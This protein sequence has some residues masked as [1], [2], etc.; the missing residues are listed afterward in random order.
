MT[1]TIAQGP[2]QTQK[3]YPSGQY[4]QYVLAVC[5]CG[6]LKEVSRSNIVSGQS[7]QCKSCS[8]TGNKNATK[9]GYD[10]TPTYV[11][12][13]EMR[14][15]VRATHRKDYQ[16]YKHVTVASEWECFDQFL[17]DMGERPEGTTLDR[18]D[19]DK[20]YTKSNCRWAD[21]LTQRHNQRR[22]R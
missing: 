14:R 2:V 20:G 13:V 11:S 18:I 7:T 10:G 22:M 5:D 6:K 19:P 17:S 12:W 21:S 16:W 8:G 1:W 9:H 3:R 15:R 4:A